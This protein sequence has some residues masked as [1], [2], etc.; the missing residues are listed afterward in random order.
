MPRPMPA[1]T[2]WPWALTCILTDH[3]VLAL[4][5]S[6]AKAWLVTCTAALVFWTS[7]LVLPISPLALS[8]PEL[9][10]TSSVSVFFA[11][12]SISVARVFAS[13]AILA[14]LSQPLRAADSSPSA[15]S[16]RPAVYTASILVR[17]EA[18]A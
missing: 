10:D 12:A 18:T 3:M 11:W 7:V 2:Y 15:L 4:L 14:V 5:S 17:I 1:A 9:N 16:S 13:S 8:S 6:A